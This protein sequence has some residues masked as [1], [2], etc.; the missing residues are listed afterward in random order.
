M[1]EMIIQVVQINFSQ[2][3]SRNEQFRLEATKQQWFACVKLK[4]HESATKQY[5]YLAQSHAISLH[6][7]N[8]NECV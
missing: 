6:A 3:K 4:I 1:K 5:L 8:I 7:R 2:A